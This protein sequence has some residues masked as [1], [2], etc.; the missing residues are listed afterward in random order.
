MMCCFPTRV[1]ETSEAKFQG[2]KFVCE[3]TSLHVSLII[4]SYHSGLH[5]INE[6]PTEAGYHKIWTWRMF[7]HHYGWWPQLPTA[8]T[9]IMVTPL[10]AYYWLKCTYAFTGWGTETDNQTWHNIM[11]S[12]HHIPACSCLMLTACAS[13]TIEKKCSLWKFGLCFWPIRIK[14]NRI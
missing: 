13:S 8:P 5:H 6:F 12:S 3:R 1:P 11:M 9:F 14:L 10:P 4:M 2:Y 7:T